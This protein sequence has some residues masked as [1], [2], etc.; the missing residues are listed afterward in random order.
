M[1]KF[2][3]YFVIKIAV[4]VMLTMRQVNGE[5]AWNDDRI[6]S[7]CSVNA[8]D[9]ST[10]IMDLERVMA[11]TSLT[12]K[13]DPSLLYES[14]LPDNVFQKMQSIESLRI[15]ACKLLA[16][17]NNTFTGMLKLRSLKI[18]TRNSEW[19]LGNKLEMENGLFAQLVEVQQ[20]TLTN[21]NLRAL[22]ANIFCPLKNMIHL[23]L[24]ENRIRT[25]NDL[26]FNECGDNLIQLK[27]IDLSANELFI[28]DHNWTRSDLR[29]L[30]TIHLQH[31]NLTK[32]YGSVFND[33]PG[34]KVLNLS[35]NHLETLPNGLFSKNVNLR[36]IYLQNNKLYQLPKDIFANLNELMVL[37]LSNN[38]LSSH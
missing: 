36:E 20:I 37:D 11:T 29:S 30:E 23:N 38:Q 24:S 18:N 33:L 28:F 3:L 10:I 35:A 31:N 4:V 1:F 22:P 9:K 32:I 21:N 19:G 2:K 34:L 13:C 7:M 15:E 27:S 6:S 26:G 5:C 8:I 12:I 25:T 16:L 17:K 14:V